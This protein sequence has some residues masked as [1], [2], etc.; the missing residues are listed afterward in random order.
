MPRKNTSEF[1]TIGI[2]RTTRDR[3]KHFARKV[4]MYDDIINRLLDIAEEQENS[5]TGRQSMKKHS[6]KGREK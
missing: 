5:S 4:E 2:R 3:L 6:R 1:T